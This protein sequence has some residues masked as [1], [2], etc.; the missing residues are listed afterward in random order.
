M[1]LSAAAIIS[2]ISVAGFSGAFAQKAECRVL[3]GHDASMLHQCGET[4]N[5]FSLQL[6]N[7]EA[8]SDLHGRIRFS[9]PIESMCERGL[10]AGGF[11]VSAAKWQDS[12]KD[13]HSI[14]EMLRRFPMASATWPMPTV[15]CRPFDI[16]IGDMAGRGI[17]LSF[18]EEPKTA[19]IVMVVADD[20][21]G[22][23]LHFYDQ[24]SSADT[25]KDKV[26]DLLSR[27][28]VE[29]AV[30]DAGLMRWIR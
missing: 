16:S 30:G 3:N 1:R 6:A 29:R 21:V 12:A 13:E 14:L 22:L 27:S 20:H 23:F 7:R 5:S 11:F 15:A 25:L 2:L 26:K 18:S 19:G 24:D 8:R 17:C 28:R 9:C 4:L 10:A